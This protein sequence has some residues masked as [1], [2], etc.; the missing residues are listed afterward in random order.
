MTV[1]AFGELWPPFSGVCRI[2]ILR[3]GGLG[4]LLLIMPAVESLAAAYPKAEITLL[5]SALHAELL[6][7][8]PSPF[9]SI[10]I[11]PQGLGMGPGVADSLATSQFLHRMQARRFDL[12]IQLHGGGRHSNPFLL[13]LGATHTVGRATEDALPLE[14]T[15]PYLHYQHD[16]IKA[17]E[18]VA[19]A[20][21]A[22]IQLEP[23]LRPDRR[24]G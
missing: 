23:Q 10:E 3:G 12:A 18:V 15:L 16:V 4:D 2:A 5:G 6:H 13:S 7:G 20:G 22:P 9:S 24:R 11:L 8:R 1:Q 19:L 21:V 14:R 17:L